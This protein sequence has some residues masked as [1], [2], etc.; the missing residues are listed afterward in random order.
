M[1]RGNN[2]KYTNRLTRTGAATKSGYMYSSR[3]SGD[4]VHVLLGV[5]KRLSEK[6][7][8]NKEKKGGEH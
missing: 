5:T 7:G 1:R 3:V 4:T 2:Q 8:V 6:R